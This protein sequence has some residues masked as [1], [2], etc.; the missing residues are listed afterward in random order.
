MQSLALYLQSVGYG[1]TVYD[2]RQILPANP[3]NQ[4]KSLRSTL[5]EAISK[6]WPTEVPIGTLKEYG[7]ESLQ[8][9]L[10][11][12]FR[13]FPTDVASDPGIHLRITGCFGD[14]MRKGDAV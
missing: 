11:M 8:R 1:G 13:F 6:Q 10:L 5:S 4:R 12:Y 7:L 3:T 2:F 14:E 9:K